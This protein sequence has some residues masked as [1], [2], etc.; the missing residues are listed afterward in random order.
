MHTKKYFEEVIAVAK[1]I[2]VAAI[3]KLASELV[4]LRKRGGGD[5]FFWGLAGALQTA[6]MRST[7][8]ANFVALRPIRLSITFRN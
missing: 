8:F 5:C 4:A 1:L 2:D 7:T 3:E 6:V